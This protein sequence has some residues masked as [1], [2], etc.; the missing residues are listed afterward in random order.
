MRITFSDAVEGFG[1]WI[2]DDG[3]A[4]ANQ[5]VMHVTETNG[6]V[7]TSAILDANNGLAGAVEGFLGAVSAMGTPHQ[8]AIPRPAPLAR[9][10][11]CSAGG[12][13]RS[14]SELTRTAAEIT[15]RS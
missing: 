8:F 2:Y 11:P 14:T 9:M 7:S 1:L 4:E 15:V 6:A 13:G 3:V 5:F 12:L 10:T